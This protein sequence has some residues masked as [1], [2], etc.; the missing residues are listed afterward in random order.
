[1]AG[2]GTF[3][4]SNFRYLTGQMLDA[5]ANTNSFMGGIV[6]Q[7]IANVALNYGDIVQITA[8]ALGVSKLTATP[9]NTIGVV[10]GGLSTNN[11]ILTDSTLVGTAL[12]A[13][14]TAPGQSVMI[15]RSGVVQVLSDTSAILI[16][17]L[18]APSTGTAGSAAL[19]AAASL[20]VA[21]GA[22]TLPCIGWSVTANGSAAVAIVAYLKG[23][24]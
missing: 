16:G 24:I 21:T 17:S 10:V 5:G 15:Q 8:T 1:M 13:C 9:F 2:F 22:A 7:M 20:N 6:N 4:A 3:K 12:G 11:E 19:L 23:L 14:T 18:I